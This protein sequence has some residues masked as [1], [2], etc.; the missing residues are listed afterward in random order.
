MVA[1]CTGRVPRREPQSQAQPGAN[2]GFA[3]DTMQF[4]EDDVSPR[5]HVTEARV[6]RLAERLTPTEHAVI[7][8]LDRF[9]LASSSQ[10]ERLHFVPNGSARTVT[11]RA[12][13]TLRRL[14]ELRI[15]ARLERR[16]GGV[17]SGSAG[18]VYALD[19]AGQRL[20]SACGPAG[21][22]R[23][24]RPWTPGAAF[25]SHQ[26][27]VTEL[28][29]RLVEAG[30]A[31]R[32]EVL[33][34][35]AEPLCWR[36]FTGLG[37]ASV[38]LK[39]DAFVRIGLADVER[40]YFVEVDRNTQSGP[41]IARKLAVYRRY[42]QTGRDQDRFGVF[43]RVLLLVPDETRQDALV[44]IAGQQPADSAALWQVA[45]YDDALEVCTAAEEAA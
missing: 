21:G 26:L 15:L 12:R 41:A 24:R 14:V 1:R 11:R 20:A 34:C 40:F 27:A 31:G 42:F 10:L 39:P 13:R 9:R 28:Y 32:L 17:R 8:T 44:G 23:L 35:D 38:T 37:G 19:V 4:A 29:V 25:V 2:C 7:E 22:V 3:N 18:Y 30:R 43:P 16:V 33:A 45:R 6:A 5:Q 36:R